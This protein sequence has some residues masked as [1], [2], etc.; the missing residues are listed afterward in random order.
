MV[1][2]GTNVPFLAIAGRQCAVCTHLTKKYRHI[3]HG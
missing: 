3:Q 2:L 1:T